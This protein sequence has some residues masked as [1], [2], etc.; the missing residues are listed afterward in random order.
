MALDELKTKLG[1]V[2]GPEVGSATKKAMLQLCYAY[3]A[4]ELSHEDLLEVKTA[5]SAVPNGYKAEVHNVFVD[6]VWLV[7]LDLPKDK[8]EDR[9]KLGP[10]VATLQEGG[11]PKTMLMERLDEHTLAAAGVV[12]SADHFKKLEPVPCV[13]LP[14]VP[15]PAPPYMQDKFNLFREDSEGYAKLLTQLLTQQHVHSM[16]VEAVQTN[17]RTYIGYFHLDPNRALSVLLDAYRH[18]IDNDAFLRLLPMFHSAAALNCRHACKQT[19][20]RRPPRH[21]FITPLLG[22]KFHHYQGNPGKQTPASLYQLAA[23]LIQHKLL[24]PSNKDAAA[25]AQNYQQLA[26]KEAAGCKSTVVRPDNPTWAHVTAGIVVQDV[27]RDVSWPT[28]LQSPL[29]CMPVCL[30]GVCLP[31]ACTAYPQ[32][33]LVVDLQELSTP[34]KIINYFHFSSYPTKLKVPDQLLDNQKFGL[35]CAILELRQMDL[36]KEYLDMMEP[37][38]PMANPDVVSALLGMVHWILEP[39]YVKVTTLHLD[40]KSVS[41]PDGFVDEVMPNL[42]HICSAL[43]ELAYQDAFLITKICRMLKGLRVTKATTEEQWT[44]WALTLLKHTLLPAMALCPPNPPMTYEMWEVLKYISLEQRYSVYGWF[45][46]VG[47]QSSW[48]LRIAETLAR[49]ETRRLLKKVSNSK[50]DVKVY[51]KGLAK[52]F[53][54][55]PI[56][57]FEQ[58]LVFCENYKGLALTVLDHIVYMNHWS[59]DLL[60]WQLL[61]RLAKPRNLLK[62][63]G[64]AVGY[65]AD[66]LQSLGTFAGLLFR[67]V[68]NY[69]NGKTIFTFL[70]HKLF[71]GE[72]SHLFIIQ[73]IVKQMTGISS[74]VDGQSKEQLECHAGGLN[75]T[76]IGG[77]YESFFANKDAPAL[78][79]ITKSSACLREVLMTGD[80]L[81]NL[82]VLLAQHCSTYLYQA[83]KD[84][85][86]DAFEQLGGESL[87]NALPL[88]KSPSPTTM[89]TLVRSYR[90]TAEAAMAIIRPS[91]PVRPLL[92]AELVSK[93]LG[94]VKGAGIVGP[95]L[96]FDLWLAFWTMNLSDVFVPT[97]RY[98]ENI[99]RIK[100]EISN[101]SKIVSSAIMANM[102]PAARDKDFDHRPQQGKHKQFMKAHYG[103]HTKITDHLINSLTSEYEQDKRK[104]LAIMNKMNEVFPQHRSVAKVLQGHVTQLIADEESRLKMSDL[105]TSTLLTMAKSM[106]SMLDKCPVKRFATV[107]KE[108]ENFNLAP[109]TDRIKRDADRK[110]EEPQS[111]RS[112]AEGPGKSPL[113][114]SQESTLKER[115]EAEKTK[116]GLKAPADSVDDKEKEGKEKVEKNADKGADKEKPEKKDKREKKDKGK[117]KDKDKDKHKH[118]KDEEGLRDKKEDQKRPDKEKKEMHKEVKDRE[119]DKSGLKEREAEQQIASAKEKEKES[120]DTGK[121]CNDEKDAKPKAEEKLNR[122]KILAGKDSSANKADQTASG[123]PAPLGRPTPNPAGS[124]PQ[125]KDEDERKRKHHHQSP[126]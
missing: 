6:A 111:K 26:T 81:Q 33:S 62:E 31:C 34:I 5:M 80:T 52:I 11:V 7:D 91:L 68:T 2:D 44:E 20:H 112:K 90:I 19:I 104:A 113:T 22:F 122:S 70:A 73:E 12:G 110:D 1:E 105:D 10:L 82:L 17:I 126:G 84:V 43:K 15:L 72:F 49:G 3:G 51:A 57:V 65:V 74:D 40:L 50:D 97:A 64:V 107:D 32:T 96:N 117:G 75:L 8:Q 94:D 29:A 56:P 47:Y 9:G 37:F 85:D 59:L 115:L 99:D 86:S 61:A 45:K 89:E 95:E 119:K 109:P 79:K 101:P 60:S 54:S 16:P 58:V 36:A 123:S 125:S 76:L 46:E 124:R 42:L 18:D 88:L 13:L 98:K 21:E 55:N 83:P 71:A 4:G 41:P 28:D 27:E 35:L 14:H 66:W 38:C 93:H 39:L 116:S 92:D 114:K 69:Y 24:L 67:K 120:K 102:K 121:S 78:T 103:W 87:S 106:V 53:H 108:D 48:R 118:K 25:A 77:G 30:P 100:S 23:R 63:D